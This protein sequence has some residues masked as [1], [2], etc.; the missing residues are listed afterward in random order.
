MRNSGGYYETLI[1]SLGCLKGPFQEDLLI[2]FIKLLS[3]ILP[4]ILLYL[5]HVCVIATRKY[6]LSPFH[7]IYQNLPATSHRNTYTGLYFY[8]FIHNTTK[9]FL[10]LGVGQK[11]LLSAFCSSLLFDFLIS[12]AGITRSIPTVGCRGCHSPLTNVLSTN[13]QI[14]H[15]FGHM[16]LLFCI[17]GT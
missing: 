16:L 11:G 1:K 10:Q 14:C 9:H 4:M 7:V 8:P 3:L 12:F 2:I 13:H 5:A 15:F 6:S 17:F